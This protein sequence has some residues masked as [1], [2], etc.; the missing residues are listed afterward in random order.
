MKFWNQFSFCK[1]YMKGEVN[2]KV[3]MCKCIGSQVIWV[4]TALISKHVFK[5]YFRERDWLIQS[6]AA[7]ARILNVDQVWGENNGIL[8]MVI[9]VLKIANNLIHCIGKTYRART[10]KFEMQR[11]WNH[12]ELCER[13]E[14]KTWHWFCVQNARIVPN[15]TQFERILYWV[16]VWSRNFEILVF[17]VFV[18][19]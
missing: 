1:L 5:K 2:A 8:V 12:F 15:C 18:G 10:L 17:G 4:N 11:I 13:N 16:N 7:E 9:K 19:W 6:R 3:S 14:L